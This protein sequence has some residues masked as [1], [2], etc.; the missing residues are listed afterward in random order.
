MTNNLTQGLAPSEE[1]VNKL[2]KKSFLKLWTHP[3]PKGKK[4]KELCDCL[5]V[6]GIH[7]ETFA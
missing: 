3:N 1:F 4:D 7:I 2:C 5:I 6:C